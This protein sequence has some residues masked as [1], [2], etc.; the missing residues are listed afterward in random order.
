M[1]DKYD[2]GEGLTKCYTNKYLS[3]QTTMFKA[4]KAVNNG[5]RTTKRPLCL[6]VGEHLLG[7]L[8]FN[9]KPNGRKSTYNDF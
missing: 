2:F 9:Q 1:E 3:L 8:M 5:Q 7:E 4:T 6:A